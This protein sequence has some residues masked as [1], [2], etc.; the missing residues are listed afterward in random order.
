[1]SA[2]E[3][4]TWHLRAQYTDQTAGEYLLVQT[5]RALNVPAVHLHSSPY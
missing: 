3:V 4:Q 5:V 1:M 2:K